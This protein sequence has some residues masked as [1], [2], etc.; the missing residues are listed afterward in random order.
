MQNNLYCKFCKHDRFEVIEVEEGSNERRVECLSC[1][2]KFKLK[3]LIPENE[4]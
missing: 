2:G 4:L 1:D 3:Q